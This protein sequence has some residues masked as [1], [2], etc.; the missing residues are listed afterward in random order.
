MLERQ[1]SRPLALQSLLK[2]SPVVMMMMMMM[3]TMIILTNL[4]TVFFVIFHIFMR[5]RIGTLSCQNV[6]YFK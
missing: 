5:D 1:S 4:V 3:M 6:V 2:W